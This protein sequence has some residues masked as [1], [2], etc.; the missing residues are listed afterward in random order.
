[1]TVSLAK[2]LDKLENEIPSIKKSIEGFDGRM[3]VMA[4]RIVELQERIEAIEESLHEVKSKKSRIDDNWNQSKL[5]EAKIP[6]PRELEGQSLLR[7]VEAEQT[8]S[9]FISQL[10]EKNKGNTNK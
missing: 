8:L 3:L 1:M 4:V 7:K 2:N 5:K 10:E 6:P 9:Q